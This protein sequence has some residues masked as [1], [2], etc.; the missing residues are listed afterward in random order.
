MDRSAKTL[1]VPFETGDVAPPVAGSDWLFLN[2]APLDKAGDLLAPAQL[3]R[4]QPSRPEF[5]AL[6]RAG[7]EAQPEAPAGRFDGVL[8]RLGK[9]RR[10]NEAMIASANGA[11]RSGG[12]VIVAGDKALGAASARKWAGGQIALGGSLAKH[13]GIAF[14]FAAAE[15]AFAGVALPQ[16]VPAPGFAA[17]P[18]MFSPDRIDEGSALLADHIDGRVAGAVADFGAGWGYLSGQVLARGNPASIDLVEAHK[19]SLDQALVNLAPLKGMVPV[20]G[21]WLDVTAEPLPGPFDWVVTNPPF[22]TSRASE[23]DLGRSFIIAA[24]KALKPSGRLLMVANRRL[25]YEQ[26][27]GDRFANCAEREACNGFKVIEA[28]RPRR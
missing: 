24:A 16:T 10:L 11:V 9:H 13:H 26:T 22:H 21:H 25:P 20:A 2:A 7:H 4:V 27:L 8:V 17:A 28:H 14:W 5:L 12:L 6:E 19:P 18:G 23:P 15:G 1:L 3:C